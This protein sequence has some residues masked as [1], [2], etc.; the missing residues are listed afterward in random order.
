MRVQ[1]RRPFAVAGPTSMEQ[2]T[3]TPLL[4]LQVVPFWTV[5]LFI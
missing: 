2:Y 3:G 1:P 4:N 5:I